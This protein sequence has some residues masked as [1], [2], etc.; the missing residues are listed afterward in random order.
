[1][2]QFN[3][4]LL[5]LSILIALTA[6]TFL[7]IPR[8]DSP[9]ADVLFYLK[10]LPVLYYVS[11]VGTFIFAVWS[12]KKILNL[13]SVLLFGLLTL[14]TPYVMYVQIWFP[15]VYFYLSEAITVKSV[16]FS[17]VA[18]HTDVSPA[19]SYL[20]GQFLIA[21]NIDPIAF[22]KLFQLL[23]IVLLGILFYAIAE[24]L[25]ISNPSIAPLVF[26]SIVWQDEISLSRLTYSLIFLLAFVLLS[27]RNS[28][29][30]NSSCSYTNYALS[31]LL[32][33]LIVISH[34]GVPLFLIAGFLAAMLALRLLIPNSG[35]Y[36]KELAIKISA[37]AFVWIAWNLT[38]ASMGAIETLVNFAKTI[39]LSL[40]GGSTSIATSLTKIGGSSYTPEYYVIIQTH[41]AH[42]VIVFALFLSIYL[43]FGFRRHPSDLVNASCFLAALLISIPLF[44]AGLPWFSRPSL[45]MYTFFA[46]VS[47]VVIDKSVSQLS[48]IR[49][50]RM[51]KTKRTIIKLR[52]V[53][54]ILLITSVF[55]SAVSLPVVKYSD[56]PFLYLPTKELEALKF[57]KNNLPTNLTMLSTSFN[58]PSG[59]YSMLLNSSGGSGSGVTYGDWRSLVG[60][61]QEYE[62]AFLTLNSILVRDAFFRVS[63][64]YGDILA[65]LTDSLSFAENKI[66][67]AGGN[68]SIFVPSQH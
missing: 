50:T 16:G 46:P 61:E 39:E 8:V 56:T 23:S 15:D 12:R 6:A 18:G 42:M 25:K 5:I 29:E 59:F 28:S 68:D 20:S 49:K 34:P 37:L 43:L 14:F 51:P 44:L 64:T 24:K 27:T 65:S 13:S 30:L 57:A 7:T 53:F 1:M 33:F 32:V 47:A 19:L 63:P 55:V 67:D 36:I 2:K 62:V 58:T 48:K 45:I 54:G 21:T 4:D 66:Y 26:F 31:F 22:A 40:M 3:R 41:L 60:T 10:S 35:S 17:G 11:I 9:G 52:H 38:R